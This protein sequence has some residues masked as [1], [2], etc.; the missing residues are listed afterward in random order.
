MT[1][2]TPDSAQPDVAQARSQRDRAR[3][4]A[5][6][7]GVAALPVAALLLSACGLLPI[8]GVPPSLPDTAPDHDP[9]PTTEPTDP[10]SELGEIVDLLG[11]D[12]PVIAV[13][14][15]IE[16]PVYELRL[17]A[18][19]DGLVP[20]GETSCET[21]MDQFILLELE[22]RIL[23]AQAEQTEQGDPFWT[24]GTEF[25]GETPDGTVAAGNTLIADRWCMAEGD[26]SLVSVKMLAGETYHGYLLIDVPEDTTAIIWK[27]T[28]LYAEPSYRWNLADIPVLP[29]LP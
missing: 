5:R 23:P 28:G 11:P 13:D 29:E 24:W 26:G 25:L 9:V 8:P 21:E 20:T 22:Y 15:F 17:L 12:D 1:L 4:R 6:R 18:Y 3:R 27:A 7:L 10:D 2:N 16:K 14:W 19:M